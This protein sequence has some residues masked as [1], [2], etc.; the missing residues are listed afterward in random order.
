[1]LFHPLHLLA[2]SLLS[3]SHLAYSRV[4]ALGTV[5]ASAVS[6][7][8]W[9]S[10]FGTTTFAHSLVGAGD[11]LWLVRGFAGFEIC[12]PSR[13]IVNVSN[14]SITLDVEVPDLL[15]SRSAQRF[16]EVAVQAAPRTHSGV[17]DAIGLVN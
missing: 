9:A 13:L 2:G 4:S 5:G 11:L 6:W 7:C 8:T 17:C 15:S 16:L 10:A 14:L 1:M 3:L 12:Q